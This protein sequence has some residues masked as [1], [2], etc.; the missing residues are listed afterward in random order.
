MEYWGK[1]VTT[2]EG[3]DK[4]LRAI[5]MFARAAAHYVTA[6]PNTLAL[7]LVDCLLRV[8]QLDKDNELAKRATLL[9]KASCVGTPFVRVVNA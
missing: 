6:Q 7:T 8:C 9:M 4:L 3:K 1:M 5:Q 2:Y